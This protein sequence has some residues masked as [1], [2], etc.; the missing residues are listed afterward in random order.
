[1]NNQFA[2]NVYYDRT[3]DCD[4]AKL[5]L[6]DELKLEADAEEVFDPDGAVAGAARE[7][8]R[9]RKLLR[10]VGRRLGLGLR[11]LGLRHLAHGLGVEL[12]VRVE[13]VRLA[14]EGAEHVVQV[15][16][17]V[18]PVHSAVGRTVDMVVVVDGVVELLV[19][20]AVG[21]DLVL[22]GQVLQVAV[23]CGVASAC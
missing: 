2:T 18:R 7:Q 14:I 22:V 4:A 11:H 16:G 17:D 1:M 20:E 15:A 3:F 9:R 8:K 13:R 21:V 19:H 12:E 10:C 5:V 6:A 23:P